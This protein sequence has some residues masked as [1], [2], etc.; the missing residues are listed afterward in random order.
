MFKPLKLVIHQLQKNTSQNEPIWFK[1]DILAKVTPSDY[2][3]LEKMVKSFNLEGVFS[4]T[5]GEPEQF[6]FIK[7]FKQYVF[8]GRADDTFIQF[9]KDAAEYLLPLL[10]KKGGARGGFYVFIEYERDSQ[11]YFGIFLIRESEGR[12]FRMD[13]ASHSLQLEPSNGMDLANMAMG[14]QIDYLAHRSAGAPCLTFTIRKQKDISDYFIEWIGCIDKKSSKTSTED[15]QNLVKSIDHLL[16][17]DPATGSPMQPSQFMDEVNNLTEGKKTKEVD[18]QQVG[19]HFFD[20]KMFLLDQAHEQNILIDTK[21]TYHQPAFQKENIVDVKDD[22]L[23]LK[24]KFPKFR[25]GDR[26]SIKITDNGDGRI[27]VIKS[28]HLIEQILKKLNDSSN[29]A[30]T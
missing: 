4:G 14:C 18:L 10:K 17:L 9:T 3:S 15:F 25:F 12:T 6:E 20:D 27:L 5:F 2:E 7:L 24:L 8:G 16:P 19:E 11:A 26:K 1:S 22:E 21:F 23:K 30:R 28:E 29:G 13:P